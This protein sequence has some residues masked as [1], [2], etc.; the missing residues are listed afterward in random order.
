[1]HVSYTFSLSHHVSRLPI[2]CS[3]RLVQT[4]AR[5]VPRVRTGDHHEVRHRS[6]SIVCGAQTYGERRHV[7]AKQH[8]VFDRRI[9][10]AID[11]VRNTAAPNCA[12]CTINEEGYAHGKPKHTEFSAPSHAAVWKRHEF[13][14]LVSGSYCCLQTRHVRSLIDVIGAAHL[15]HGGGRQG[16]SRWVVPR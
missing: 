12:K 1:M 8:K 9:H 3:R 15:R 14:P 10:E 5:Y 4:G 2:P 11:T 7:S 6:A 16:G 13:G